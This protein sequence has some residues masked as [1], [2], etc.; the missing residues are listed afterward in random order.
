MKPC[1]IVGLILFAIALS[2]TAFA[3]PDHIKFANASPWVEPITYN[4]KGKPDAGQGSGYYYLL[5]DEQ[6]NTITQEDYYHYAYV[7]LTSEGV[8]EMSDL[9]FNFDPSYQQLIFHEVKIIRGNTSYN[10][11][12]KDIQVIQREQ[13]M[14]RYLYDGSKTAVINLKDIRVGD[15]VEYSFTRKG[16][17]PIHKGHVARTYYLDFYQS[18]D[19]SFR[20]LIL[21]ASK[22]VSVKSL[23]EKVPEPQITKTANEVH[24]TWNIG[25]TNPPEYDNNTPAWYDNSKVFMISDFESWEAVGQWAQ[26]LFTVS[27]ADKDKIKK[28]VASSFQAEKDS[29]YILEVIRFV[30]DEVRYLGFESGINSHKPYPPFQIYDQRFGDCKDKS[31]LLTT[32]LQARGIEAYPMLVNTTLKHTIEDRLPSSLF[33]DHCVVQIIFNDAK[34]YIDPTVSNQGGDLFHYYF[35]DYR[36]GLVIDQHITALDSLPSPQTPTTTEVQNFTVTSIGGAAILTVKTTYTGSD[37]DYQ[38][39]EF[40]GT[41]LESIQKRYKQYY[42]NLYPD[43]T[44]WGKL[45]FH[46]DRNSNI[47]T[48][49]EKYSIP[50]FWKPIENEEN[51]IYCIFEPQSIANYFNVNKNIQQRTSPYYL[52]YP[53]NFYHHINVTLPESWTVNPVDEEIENDF[54]LYEYRINN[55]GNEFSIMTHYQTKTDHIPVDKIAQYIKDHSKMYSHLTYELNYNNDIA[56]ASKNIL[57]GIITTILSIVAGVYSMFALYHRYD[58]KPERFLVH[59]SPIGGWLILIAIGLVITPIRLL[60]DLGSN[61]HLITGTGWMTWL[62]AK[63][64]GLFAFTFF[65]HV[66]NIIKLLFSV[67]LVVLFFQRRSSFPLLMSIQLATNFIVLTADVVITN[68]ATEESSYTDFQEIGKTLLAA[69]IWIPYLNISQRVKET[70]TIRMNDDDEDDVT[71]VKSEIMET[72]SRF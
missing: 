16:Y 35:P 12:S 65:S 15:I 69:I 24:Y 39:S 14:D 53:V 21:P 7:I 67:L 57:P 30:Q 37:A 70:F 6:E 59:G 45:T 2:L 72:D 36:R 13:S 40:A 63:Q 66:Y 11:L 42:A 46:D 25:R 54:Y 43:I 41:P 50:T 26:N 58:P 28:E 1:S 3:Q 44:N 23:G 48:V 4:E 18:I 49:E 68:Y 17:N 56:E 20:K 52:S 10:K 55:N 29:A 62:S 60:M 19:K 33:F 31:L 64:Y 8:Q 71:E 51:K 22:K 5:S 38:R 61:A 47:F 32:L 27:Q 34:I 9:N